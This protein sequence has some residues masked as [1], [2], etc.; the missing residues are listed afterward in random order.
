MLN[1]HRLLFGCFV[2]LL[3]INSF[4]VFGQTKVKKHKL[5]QNHK[6]TH[7]SMKNSTTGPL[8]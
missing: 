3:G 4:P 6:P 5:F 2:V 7:R 1:F 8:N